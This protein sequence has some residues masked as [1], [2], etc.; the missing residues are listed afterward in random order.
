METL[1]DHHN[2][3][4]QYNQQFIAQLMSE[5]YDY[6]QAV[7]I[8]STEMDGVGLCPEGV[9]GMQT[10]C[11]VLKYS[12]GLPESKGARDGE[13]ICTEAVAQ[14]LA[15]NGFESLQDYYRAMN[16]GYEEI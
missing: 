4:P 6:S 16:L 12:E 13:I 15:E 11:N 8:A 10:Y 7:M 1:R 3:I 2:N 14:W 5:G 9:N